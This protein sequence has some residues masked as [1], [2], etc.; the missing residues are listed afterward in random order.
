MSRK[1]I[2]Y[3]LQQYADNK[4]TVTE[5]RE[6]SALLQQ[7]AQKATVLEVIEEG[8]E[9]TTQPVWS[10]DRLDKMVQSVLHAD[11]LNEPVSTQVKKLYPRH[12]WMAAAS[13]MVLI[14]VGIG[15][16]YSFHKPK[17]VPLAS[18]E[19]RFKND[20]GPGKYKAKLTLANGKTIVL[21]SVSLGE[22]TREGGIVVL[23]KGGRL[24]YN[25]N[26]R[27]AG[28]PLLYNT[29]STAN[30]ETYSTVLSDGTKVWLNS[31]SSIR[32]PVAFKG[33]ERSVEITGEAY[34]EVIHNARIPFRVKAGNQV[35]EDIGTAF[36]VEAYA[37][38]PEFKT[39]LVEGSAKVTSAVGQRVFHILRRGEQSQLNAAGKLKVVYD[40]NMDEIL[41]WKNG[42]FSFE[43]GDVSTIMKA[44]SRWYGLNVVYKTGT[45]KEKIHLEAAR[46]TSLTNVLKV[47][48]LT[49]GLR[50]V[51]EG[52]N[53]T[54]LE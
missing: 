33:N 40:A 35:I 42:M 18:Q 10:S 44:L 12:L 26:G 8:L 52:R 3:L 23:N 36:N 20:I 4:A 50:F 16:F 31:G 13:I 45:V 54:V 2:S 25:G 30:G 32:F 46:N 41:A 11:Q 29:L 38:E 7:P 27:L 19:K 49:S 1:R 17:T 47:M 14:S 9:S 34:F 24:I 43:N 21:D 5:V 53:V 48:E 37:D 15:L 39:T 51:I 22:L 28:A 6:L